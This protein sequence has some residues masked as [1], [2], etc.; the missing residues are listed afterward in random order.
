M[1]TVGHSLWSCQAAKDVWL[2]C[3][4]R[5]QKNPCDE[6]DFSSIFKCAS[7]ASNGRGIEVAG[8]CCKTNLALA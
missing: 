2:E 5:I 8:V 4:L 3:P 1:E 6:D 7:G